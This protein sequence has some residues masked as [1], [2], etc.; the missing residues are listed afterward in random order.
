[1][2]NK[3]VLIFIVALTFCL[4]GIA[5]EVH[6][7][8]SSGLWHDPLVWNSKSVPGKCDLVV[9]RHVIESTES[10]NF[11][12]GGFLHIDQG[13]WLCAADSLI[14]SCG[15]RFENHGTV[16]T[17]VLKVRDGANTGCLMVGTGPVTEA[18]NDAFEM[19]GTVEYVTDFCYPGFASTTPTLKNRNLSP[20][21]GGGTACPSNLLLR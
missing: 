17:P 15:S 8:V 11:T 20:I 14:A 9:V 1:M 5:Q 6:Q 18:C 12:A 13:G 21:P 7:T 16:V 10:I 3:P 4:R 2:S 19:G